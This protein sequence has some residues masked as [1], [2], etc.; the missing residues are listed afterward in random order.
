MPPNTW[1]QADGR[2]PQVDALEN[3][4]GDELRSLAPVPQLHQK[5]LE[6]AQVGLPKRRRLS[7]ST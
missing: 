3:G 6:P 7:G 2:R 4:H 1:L 5:W